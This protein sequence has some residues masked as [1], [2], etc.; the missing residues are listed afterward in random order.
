MRARDAKLAILRALPTLR[1]ASDGELTHIARLTELV[2]LPAGKVLVKE[3]ETAKEG[4]W[5]LDGRLSVTVGGRVV[6]VLGTGD[7][8]GELALLD[9][10]P[11]SA[12]LTAAV[13][14]R[15]LV[16]DGPR[17]RALCELPIV[18]SALTRQLAR[19]LRGAQAVANAE[20]RWSARRCAHVRFAKSA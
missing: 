13:P 3:G 15:A 18:G 8:A 5:I 17:F 11:R 9:P 12:T 16:F 6:A 1:G 14:T 19:R 2:E 10:A 4:F 20:T 7:F